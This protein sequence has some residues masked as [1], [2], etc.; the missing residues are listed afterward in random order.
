MFSRCGGSSASV[1]SKLVP[2]RLPTNFLTTPAKGDAPIGE[3]KHNMSSNRKRPRARV[4]LSA[5]IKGN[6]A[7][8]DVRIRDISEHGARLE[9]KTPPAIDTQLVFTR[10]EID[11]DARVAWVDGKIFG[12]E[13]ID[14]VNPRN[15]LPQVSTPAPVAPTQPY[16]RPSLQPTRL[17]PDEQVILN[18]LKAAGIIELP[19]H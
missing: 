10:G 3:L 7:P 11:V 1:T 4:L 15:I 18:K 5:T 17:Q 16:R 2:P 12:L 6:G 8:L 14:A 19:R 9:S 13:F